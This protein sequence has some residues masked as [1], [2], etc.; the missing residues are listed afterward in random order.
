M[1]LN[2]SVAHQC[3]QKMVLN[4][5]ISVYPNVMHY[6]YTVYKFKGPLFVFYWGDAEGYSYNFVLAHDTY[7]NLNQIICSNT[8]IA[9]LFCLKLCN[10]KPKF[11]MNLESMIFAAEMCWITW[12]IFLFFPCLLFC[13][14]PPNIKF[15]SSELPSSFR[16]VV[17]FLHVQTDW[18]RSRSVF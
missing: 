10:I 13:M 14:Q 1:D 7:T 12:A 17:M 2:I 6:Q 5:L 8:M 11:P 4:C 18:L 16:R 15:V 3:C 9:V